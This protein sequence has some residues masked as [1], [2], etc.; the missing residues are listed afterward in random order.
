MFRFQ[1]TIQS[2]PCPGG[3]QG[4]LHVAESRTSTLDCFDV[5]SRSLFLWFLLSSVLCVP[6]FLW[7]L[8]IPSQFSSTPVF[9]CDGRTLKLWTIFRPFPLLWQI[10]DCF[11]CHQNYPVF[12]CLFR[13]LECLCFSVVLCYAHVRR[14]LQ[15][16][17]QTHNMDLSC[18]LPVNIAIA[19][20]F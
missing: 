2:K 4:I 6:H 11:W 14:I 19:R 20:G 12:P 8:T 17:E 9:S 16:N 1:Q 18:L 5:V 15:C 3:P 7:S 13:F 10:S